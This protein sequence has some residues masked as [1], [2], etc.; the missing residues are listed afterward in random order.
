MITSS[1]AHNL[2]SPII[3]ALF[4]GNGIVVK[5]S[6]HVAFTSFHL[7]RAV[8][9]CLSACSHDPDIVQ[10]LIGCEA[11]V[12]EALTGDERIRHITFIGSESVGRKVAERAGGKGIQVCLELGGKVRLI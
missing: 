12:A 3:T 7:L 4:S 8:R 2:L 10:A 1:A 11:D 6:E 5:P 9:S